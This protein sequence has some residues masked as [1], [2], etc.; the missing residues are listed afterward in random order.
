MNVLKLSLA[1]GALAF[2]GVVLAQAAADV[3]PPA[4]APEISVQ[5]AP[6]R[7]GPR[8]GERMQGHPHGHHHG[9][10]ARHG[11]FL[12]GVDTDRDGQV[13]RDELQA[14][15]QRQLT[16]FDRADTDKDGKLSRDEMRAARNAMHQ[17][18]RDRKAGDGQPG[19]RRAPATPG[20]QG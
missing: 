12:K 20:Q 4:Q 17:A 8:H 11:G 18:Y 3:A 9:K 16:M 14:A 7:A 10:H 5:A 6:D 13:S 19:E 2:G 15:Q 1:A